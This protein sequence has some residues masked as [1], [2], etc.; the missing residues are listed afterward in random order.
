VKAHAAGKGFPTADG[1]IAAIAA[2]HD[3]VI[4]S[5]DA[6]AFTAAGRTVIGPW[7]VGA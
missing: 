5:R 6:A 3:F 7:S 1:T 2:P 4:A